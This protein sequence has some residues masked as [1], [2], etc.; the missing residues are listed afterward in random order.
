MPYTTVWT[1]KIHD[2]IKNIHPA[3]GVFCGYNACIDFQEYLDPHVL[4]A[5]YKKYKSPELSK[6]IESKDVAKDVKTQEDFLASLVT[7]VSSGK[8]LQI[9]TY[10]TGDLHEWFN[11][12]FDEADEH[13]MGGQSGIIANLLGQLGV[14]TLAYI[15]NL[16]KVQ[17]RRFYNKNILFP[18]QDSE[19]GTFSLR[20]I[21]KCSQKDAI[22]KVNWIFE[23]EEGLTFPIEYLSE[24]ITAPRSNRL[25]VASRPLGLMP[26][27]NDELLP[28][29]PELGS[30][31]ERAILS[32]Y[33]YLPDE[34]TATSWMDRE[35]NILSLIK[36]RNRNLK[37]HL[38]FASIRNEDV[39]KIILRKISDRVDSFGCNEIELQTMLHDLGEFEAEKAL[40]E[41]E[42][43]TTIYEGVSIVQQ[44][45]KFPRIHLHTLGNHILFL[46]PNYSAEVTLDSATNGILFSS[47]VGTAKT[48]VG[49]FTSRNIMDF[50]IQLAFQIQASFTGIKALEELGQYLVNQKII[51]NLH[52]FLFNGIIKTGKLWQVIVPVQITPSDR[53]KSTVGL[54]DSISSTGFVFDRNEP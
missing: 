44:K 46:D 38:E 23:Y 39:R 41:H 24:F 15:P 8:A 11:E 1:K 30:L 10:D 43:L 21:T 34:N 26:G 27:F 17:S 40:K 42:S 54:G 28:Y 14:K 13:R 7:A 35:R 5:L 9:P 2:A 29:I 22:T 12:I 31:I 49:E 53:L 33:Q 19:T 16:S 36:S 50:E 48:L 3:R 32:G 6:R 37:I 25:I 45:L 4:E 47:A 51:N 18:I 52:E 20:N